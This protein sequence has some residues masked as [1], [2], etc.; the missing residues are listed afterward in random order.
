MPYFIQPN[1]EGAKGFAYHGHDVTDPKDPENSAH[2]HRFA[3]DQ[4]NSWKQ[5]YVEVADKL[6]DPCT[7][8]PNTITPEGIQSRPEARG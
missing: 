8:L 5:T 4:A 1:N 7:L 6:G 3:Q 2:A